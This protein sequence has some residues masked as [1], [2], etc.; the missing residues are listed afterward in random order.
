MLAKFS[1]FIIITIKKSFASVYSVYYFLSKFFAMFFLNYSIK[2]ILRNYNISVCRLV[3]NCGESLSCNL[4]FMRWYFKAFWLL[5]YPFVAHF[6]WWQ[7]YQVCFKLPLH[8]VFRSF[9]I[10]LISGTLILLCK[11]IGTS[12]FESW[13]SCFIFFFYNINFTRHKSQVK[14]LK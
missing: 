11:N 6:K 7:G 2:N 12:F 4:S 14:K 3:S 9:Y 10:H 1:F 13:S 8:S 5:C